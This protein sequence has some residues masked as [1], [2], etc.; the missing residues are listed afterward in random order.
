MKERSRYRGL[1]AAV[2]FY[3][4]KRKIRPGTGNERKKRVYYIGF[5]RRRRLDPWY[6]SVS[7]TMDI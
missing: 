5:D 3:A 4:Q 1:L 7:W 2:L 6:E